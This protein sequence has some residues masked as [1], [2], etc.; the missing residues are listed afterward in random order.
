MSRPQSSLV[1]AHA[2]ARASP[3][4]GS[5]RHHV[6]DG[7]P[8]SST[9]SVRRIEILSRWSMPRLLDGAG[10]Y[11]HPAARDRRAE[12]LIRNSSKKTITLDTIPGSQHPRRNCDV[13][14]ITP[15]CRRTFD[16]GRPRFPAT[17]LLNAL[18]RMID[19]AARTVTSK[20]P[21]ELQLQAASFVRL[22]TRPPN[23]E[24]PC[25]ITMRD[26]LRN[27]LRCAPPHHPR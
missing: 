1:S 16:F 6:S 27:A 22:E 23:L 25:S 21:A 17:T 20:T 7:R 4:R 26:L 2:A 5:A 15:A 13:S 12:H 24:G 18:S 14:Q 10:Q 9:R 11:H 19:L 3:R 8:K